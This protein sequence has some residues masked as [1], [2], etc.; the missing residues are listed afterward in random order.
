MDP[1]SY[2]EFGRLAKHLR[3]VERS[4]RRLARQTFY[5]MGRWQA[6]LEHKQAFLGRIVDIG[7]ELFAMA[8]CCSRA[9]ML[10]RTAPERGA[11]AY[12][13]ADAFCEQ[14]R[15]RV[16]EYFDQLWRN[17]DDARP[18]AGPQGPGRRLRVARG[19]RTRPV[20]RHRTVDRGRRP[21]RLGQGEPAPQVPLTGP[22]PAAARRDS[23]TRSEIVSILA[24]GIPAVVRWSDRDRHPPAVPVIQS[25]ASSPHEQHRRPRRPDAPPCHAGGRL[26]HAGR[27]HTRRPPGQ[28]QRRRRRRLCPPQPGRHRHR[29]PQVPTTPRDGSRHARIRRT[30]SATLPPAILPRTV[31]AES[32]TRETVVAREKEQFGGIKVGSAFFGW[33]TATGTAVLLTA[34]VAAG[35]HRRRAGHQHRRQRRRRTRPQATRPSGLAGIIALLVI[36]LVAYYC[37]GY[38]AGRMAR[39]NGARQGFMVW[40]WALIAAIVVAVLGLVAGQQFNILA[41]L[42]SF[43]RIPVNEGQLN[44]M[45]I[46]A[47]VVVAVVALVGAVLGG[48]AGMRFHRKVDRRGLHPGGNGRGALGG[49]DGVEVVPAAVFPHKAAG[50][51]LDPAFAVVP[52]VRRELH[53]AFAVQR[54]APASGNDVQAP[55][56]QAGIQFQ[57]RRAACPGA[58]SAAGSPR[59]A[60]RRRCTGSA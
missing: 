43:P 33:L 22:M 24:I 18:R 36:L 42:N 44:T 32:P 40:V 59:P 50:F 46:I 20:R 13:L 30:Q 49:R 2:G 45:S 60:P 27:P 10:L 28:P 57:L 9:E 12:E 26:R 48:L 14:A 54:T 51:V 6:K 53:R 34:L 23:G 58:R 15:V 19:R 35:R 16:D 11:S 8:A 31:V 7:A 37:G 56:L 38:V 1:R 47:A 21:G 39:F 4:S 3:F 55:P 52:V 17:T 25:K 5:G 41:N 29:T